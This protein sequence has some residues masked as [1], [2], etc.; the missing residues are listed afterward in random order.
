MKS[1]IQKINSITVLAV[2]ELQNSMR[3]YMYL[4]AREPSKWHVGDV[5]H[6]GRLVLSLSAK[7]INSIPMVSTQKH[8]TM[9]MIHFNALERAL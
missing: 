4:L 2:I 7:Q 8:Q 1:K 6:L 5:E 9:Q 3:R